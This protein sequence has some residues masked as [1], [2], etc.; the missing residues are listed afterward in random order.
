MN[1]IY[2]KI[3]WMELG[4]GN[5]KIHEEPLEKTEGLVLDWIKKSPVEKVEKAI[6]DD[7]SFLTNVTFEDYYDG[8]FFGINQREKDK[9]V[10]RD[11]GSI[12][13]DLL[14]HD[15]ALLPT[16]LHVAIKTKMA[17]SDFTF[18]AKILEAYWE[19]IK[20][21]ETCELN[22]LLNKKQGEEI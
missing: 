14:V 10:K 20:T 13:P 17:P 21:P 2:S 22:S 6:F 9:R 16:I 19:K 3:I 8:P 7:L 1:T 4:L 18:M 5:Y 12:E 11:D 15:T